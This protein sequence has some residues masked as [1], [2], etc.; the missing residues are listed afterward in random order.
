[1]GQN[2]IDIIAAG[3]NLEDTIRHALE[4]SPGGIS[5]FL[6]PTSSPLCSFVVEETGAQ[7][8]VDF[9]QKEEAIIYADSDLDRCVEGKQYHDAVGGGIKRWM[10]FSCR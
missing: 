9:L 5:M 3:S 7:R 2:A 6:D 1:M 10:S 4:S 8:P